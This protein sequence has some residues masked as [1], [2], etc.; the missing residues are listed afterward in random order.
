MTVTG[1]DESERGIGKVAEEGIGLGLGLGGILMP[2]ADPHT[3]KGKRDSLSRAQPLAIAIDVAAH[4]VERGDG[5]QLG[6]HVRAA[7][8]ARVQ[9]R[10]HSCK[11]GVDV[12]VNAAMRVADE[13]ESE[14]G[15]EALLRAH[16]GVAP[17]GQAALAGSDLRDVDFLHVE[18]VLRGPGADQFLAFLILAGPEDGAGV[19]GAGE[20]NSG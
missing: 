9:D 3:A 20:E 7:H 11:M 2:V 17:R 16:A 15:H 12:A 18:G 8:V 14:K 5:L 6:N 13:T 4:G 1:Q 10:L 19:D